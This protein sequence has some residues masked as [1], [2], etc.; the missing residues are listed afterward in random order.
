MVTVIGVDGRPLAPWAAERLAEATLVVGAARHLVALPV[1]RQAE[2]VVLGQVTA[3]VRALASHDGP[4]VVLAS[5]DPGFFGL[6]RL[7][8]EH[9]LDVEVA[10]GVSSVAAAF[11]QA[12]LNWDDAVVVSAHGRDPRRAVNAC[13]ALAKVA[14]LTAPGAGPAEIGAALRGWPRRLLV[15]ERLGT[16]SRRVTACTPEEAA[17]R[18]WADPNVVL[19][20]ADRPSPRGWAAPPRPAP[21]RWAL[22]EECFEHRDGMITK[23]EVRALALAHLGPGLGDLV[24]DLGCGSGSVAVEAARF[25]AAVV[26]VDRDPG[27]CDRTRRNAAAYGAEVRVVH[28]EVPGCLTGLPAPDA[29]FVGGG[30]ADVVGHVA[31]LGARTVVAA[32]AAVDRVP[33]ARDALRAAAY[34]VGGVSLA[35]SRFADLPGGATRLAAANPVF[36]VWG[37]R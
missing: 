23:A 10:P 27:Q 5:G 15:A 32:L 28:G 12:G 21:E 24:W 31:R 11:G 8:R 19:S 9:G 2:R 36:L 29:V 7:L 3:G 18:E 33:A 6:V 35:A 20:L 34:D 4:A 25:G 26:A 14:V 22:P 17:G 37:H 13:R 30:G 1:P 16:A